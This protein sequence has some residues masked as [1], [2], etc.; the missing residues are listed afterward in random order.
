VE[1]PYGTVQVK[2][3]RWKGRV[4]TR[5]P[6]YEDCAAAAEAYGAPVKVVYEVALKSL[7]RVEVGSE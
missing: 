6:E 3:G 7:E 5:A 1:T 2:V 4:V